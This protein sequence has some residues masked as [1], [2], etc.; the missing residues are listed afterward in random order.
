MRRCK[1]MGQVLDQVSRKVPVPTEKVITQNFFLSKNRP[2]QQLS[3]H[4]WHLY[5]NMSSIGDIFDC[6]PKT[7]RFGPK[8]RPIIF[9]NFALRPDSSHFRLAMSNFFCMVGFVWVLAT[10]QDLSIIPMSV[11]KLGFVMF[12]PSVTRLIGVLIL[13]FQVVSLH[14]HNVWLPLVLN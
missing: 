9:A 4:V 1:L 2:F 11:V 7:G 6:L 12:S 10:P 3:N 8:F 13:F 5:A 14:F